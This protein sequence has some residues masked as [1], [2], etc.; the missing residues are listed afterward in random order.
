MSVARPLLTPLVPLYAA[1]M[2]WKN[3]RFDT[4]T[5][6]ESKL[7]DPVVSVGSLSAGGAG[8]TPFLIAL[9]GLLREIG[10]APDVLSR[11]YGRRSRGVLR[12]DPNGTAGQFGDEPLLLARTLGCPVYVAAKRYDAGRL[13]EQ[14]QPDTG[15]MIH[16]LDDGFGHRKLART[17]DIV[18]LTAAELDDT[19][20]PAG[21]LREPLEALRRADIVV[22]RAG[23]QQRT[24]AAVQEVLG[25]GHKKPMWTIAR[26]VTL[27][28][29]VP[30]RPF[31]FSG[32]ARPADFEAMLVQRGVAA[33]GARRFRDHHAYAPGAIRKLVREAKAADAD[34]FLTTSK[35]AVK[36][37]ASMRAALEAL[38]PIAVADALVT[39]CDRNA[40]AEDLRRLLRERTRLGTFV[41]GPERI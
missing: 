4:Q 9:A 20:L 11:G 10:Y 27:P 25:P 28:A 5:S 13:A 24:L 38:G 12:V 34:R 15:R 31:V 33:A 22:L 3:R 29:R 18:L 1:A 21:N 35:D 2:R 40:C 7:R 36:L 8:K 41:V 39:L 17:I 23:E 14:S 26:E 6:I 19:L 30:L 16:L 37:D 32:I